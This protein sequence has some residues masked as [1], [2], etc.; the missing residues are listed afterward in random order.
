MK[1]SRVFEVKSGLEIR[2]I[3]SYLRSIDAQFAR[4]NSELKVEAKSTTRSKF[5][6]ETEY[7]M[8]I[9]HLAGEHE[10]L[11]SIKELAEQLAIVALYRVVELNIK[12]I[13][14]WRYTPEEVKRLETI[15]QIINR[16]NRDGIHLEKVVHFK[17]AD[18]A[19]LLNNAIKH[20]NRVTKQLAKY[21]RWK[22]G[23]E[24]KNLREAYMRLSPDIPKF[25]GFLAEKVVP[26]HP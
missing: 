11:E 15:K 23:K 18:E 16:L 25:L 1:I 9:D 21:S 26:P 7:R 17:G 13:L 8:H 14:R 10:V 4:R 2:L 19:R 22:E 6:D 12:Q 24:L 20:K 3:D 5:K